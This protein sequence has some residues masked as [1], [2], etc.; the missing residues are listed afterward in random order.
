MIGISF[1]GIEV[2]FTNDFSNQS[3]TLTWTAKHSFFTMN[4]LV[5]LGQVTSGSGDGWH[6]IKVVLSSLT[7]QDLVALTLRL[8]QASSLVITPLPLLCIC[9]FFPSPF[10]FP[11]LKVQSLSIPHPP[12]FLTFIT[13][14]K[15]H[16]AVAKP[17]LFI[18][19]QEQPLLIV[20]SILGICNLL[21]IHRK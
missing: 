3:N 4:L 15:R 2:S 13:V 21:V 1:L 12:P 9:I 14:S 7:L 16:V 17:F 6:W 8:Y 5:G 18:V 20:Q 10:F 11:L 19:H